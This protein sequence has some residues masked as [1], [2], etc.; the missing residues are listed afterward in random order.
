M[1]YFTKL[2][3]FLRDSDQDEEGGRRRKAQVFFLHPFPH[4]HESKTPFFLLGFQNRKP[5]SVNQKRTEHF[6][7]I[8]AKAQP[9][10]SF[11]QTSFILRG[12]TNDNKGGNFFSL[13]ERFFA[14]NCSSSKSLRH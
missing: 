6:L 12:F 11:L 14:S 8:K 10:I 9:C 13:I 3:S 7:A 2:S 4:L 5:C 1:S